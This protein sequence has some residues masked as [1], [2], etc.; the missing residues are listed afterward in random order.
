M[1]HE[2]YHRI[3]RELKIPP[4]FASND[5]LDTVEGRVWLQLEWSALQKALASRDAN[6]RRQAIEDA[7]S[8]RNY[9]RALFPG[10]AASE[11]ALEMN[12]GLAEYTG[13]KIAAAGRKEELIES[14]TGQIDRRRQSPSFVGSFAY[15]SGPA[16]GVLLDE[17][18]PDWRKSLTPVDD[19]AELLQRSLAIILK[20]DL[21]AEAERQAPRYGGDA[22]RRA[23]AARETARQKQTEEYRK[24]LVEG[25]VLEIVLTDKR[26]VAINSGNIVPLD[27]ARKVYPTA[28]VTDEWGILEVA[29]GALMTSEPGGRISRVYVPMPAETNAQTL[30]GDGWTLEMSAGWTLVPGARKGDY[31]L[32]RSEP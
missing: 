25:P 17:A 7:L 26:I 18:R 21:K 28:R 31:I 5:H 9:R 23:E 4:S 1:I 15:S 3:Q 20:A 24:K 30:K 6:E 32:K 2:S 12:E 29:G 8:F 27:G 11:R 22:L 19:L 16:Y 10:A 13:Y 14:L